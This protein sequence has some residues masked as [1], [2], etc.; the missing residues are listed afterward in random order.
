M[1]QCAEDTKSW[2]KAE[3]YDMPLIGFVNMSSLFASA[4]TKDGIMKAM[5]KKSAKQLGIQNDPN[6][7][8]LEKQ[9]RKHVI[10]LVIDEI[11]ML[12]KKQNSDGERFLCE[13]IRLTKEENLSFGVIGISNSVNDDYSERI[14][15]IG[16]VRAY[17]FVSLCLSF[18]F[19]LCSHT[20]N[21]LSF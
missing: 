20:L 15:E 7:Q 16:S 4:S 13:L 12:I 1:Q 21:L 9:A 17:S 19:I 5:L 6:I 8:S 3:G 18:I 11:D 2:A 10:I 14:K